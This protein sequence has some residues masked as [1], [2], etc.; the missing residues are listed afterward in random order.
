MAQ[1][2]GRKQTLPVAEERLRVGK[3]KVETGRVRVSTRTEERQQPIREELLREEVAVERVRID[4]F[5]D[6]EP[7]MRQDGDVL[8]VPVFEEVLVKRI[9]VREEL[10]ITRKRR[11]DKVEE[12]V[13]LKHQNVV[14]ERTSRR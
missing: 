5:S 9:L 13:T 1:R 7:Q 14:V 12:L 2:N 10:R 6:T 11:V 4:R 3:R 8:I